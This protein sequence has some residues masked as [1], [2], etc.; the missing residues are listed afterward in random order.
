VEVRFSADVDDIIRQP[1]ED[2]LRFSSATNKRQRGL[3]RYLS[4]SVFAQIALG[5]RPLNWLL[6]HTSFL[7]NLCQRFEELVPALPLCGASPI[8]VN[9]SMSSHPPYQRTILPDG[10]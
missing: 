2:P 5:R 7:A 9:S 10:P 4:K 6:P 8:S 3:P 1:I